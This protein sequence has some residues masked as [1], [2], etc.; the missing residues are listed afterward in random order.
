MEEGT[1]MV[2]VRVEAFFICGS[3]GQHLAILFVGN[4]IISNFEILLPQ[5]LF[6]VHVQGFYLHDCIR[7]IHLIPPAK[8]IHT[9]VRFY[10]KPVIVYIASVLNRYN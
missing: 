6:P 4:N 7:Y 3:L 5:K 10:T 8:R 9:I 2:V 1:V